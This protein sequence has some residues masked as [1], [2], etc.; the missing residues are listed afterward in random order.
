MLSDTYEVLNR[1]NVTWICANC[2]TPNH[3]VALLDSYINPC[4]NSFSPLSCVDS[5]SN[6]STNSSIPG[7]THIGSPGSPLPSSS[8]IQP[9]M[10]KPKTRPLK[11]LSVNLQSLPAKKGHHSEAGSMVKGATSVK[12]STKTHSKQPTSIEPHFSDAQNC[13]TTAPSGHHS[14]A[15]S[16]VKGATS[17]K[18][19]T[20]THSKQPTSIKPHF[21]D[22]QNC[23]T[24]APSGHHSK[25][26]SMVKGATSVKSSSKTHSKQ[27]ASI[28]PHFS[29][30]QNCETTAPSGHHSKAGSMVKG[31][32][33]VKSSTK[34]VEAAD[35]DQATLL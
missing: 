7:D 32:T 10:F 4:I 5:D 8:T 6:N 11:I 23:E 31:A 27:P 26:G 13:E 21:S 33:S 15:G 18:S 28:E 14:K 35:V 2:N 16:M 25:A 24:T 1:T 30:A 20:K 17:V 34:T 29:D 12:S 22:A 3:S 19:S 9:S